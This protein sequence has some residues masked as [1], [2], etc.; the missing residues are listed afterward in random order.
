MSFF[1]CST[2][3]GD[4]MFICAFSLS[5]TLRYFVLFINLMTKNSSEADEKPDSKKINLCKRVYK[6]S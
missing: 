4:F 3:T 1:L 2:Q 6:I 5:P